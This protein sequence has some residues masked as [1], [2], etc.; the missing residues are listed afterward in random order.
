MRVLVVE[1]DA[2]VSHWIGSKLHASGHN[3][4]L[5]DD[6]EGALQMIQN[7]AFD[8]VI[9]DRVLPRMDGIEL[10]NRLNGRARPPIL[11]LS[12]NDQIADRVEGLRAGADDYL[13][14]PFDFTELLLRLEL[15]AKRN[16]H[17]QQDER[18]HIED[19]CID[20]NRREVQRN[21]NSIDLTDKEFKLLQVLAEHQ[22]QTVTRAMLLEK[23][24]GY[25]FDPQ[26]N[27]ID[28]HLSK[29]RNKI[30][31]G[32]ER[33]LIRTIRAIGYVLG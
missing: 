21:G 15:L 2:S 11:V 29:L 25:H 30:D 12:A 14:K 16:T 31:K 33:P 27:L 23:V 6:G 32:F 4:R 13:G 3:F 28:V 22:G 1:D 17:L 19:L 5:A 8:V 10:L 9:L 24:W 26:T 7:E 20:L 18:L